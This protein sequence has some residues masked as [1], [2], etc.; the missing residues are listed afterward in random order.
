M[1][2]LTG[3]LTNQELG[4]SVRGAGTEVPVARSC[5]GTGPLFSARGQDLESNQ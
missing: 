3:Y 5:F 2:N 4:G 1:S